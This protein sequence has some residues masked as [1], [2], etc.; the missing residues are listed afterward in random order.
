MSISQA[1]YNRAKQIMPGGVQLLSKRPEM[2][3]PE[4][5]PNYA[6][7]G[8][9]CQLWDLDGNCYYDMTTNGIGACLLGYADPDVSKAAIDRINNGCMTS[10]NAPEEV[11]LAE[12]LLGIHPWAE[13]VRFARTGGETCAIAVRIARATT[14]RDVIAICG[15]HGWADWYLACN[16]SEG[17]ALDGIHLAGL[18]PAGVPS[19][20]A[21]S[22]VTFHYNNV[23]EFDAIIA[24]YGDRL[25]GVIMEPLRSTMPNDGFLQHVCDEVHRVGGL[26]LFD[27][28][29]IGWRF[30][31]GGSHR[32]LGVQ[33]DI[34]VFAKA[35]GNGHPIGAIIGT[36]AA[37]DGAHNSFISSTYWTE[38]VGPTAA[39][40]TLEKMEK[41]RVWEHAAHIGSIIQKDWVEAAANGGVKVST[42]GVPCH[43]QFSWNEDCPKE[44]K[45]LFTKLMLAE[46]FM[47]TPLCYPTLAHNEEIL[48]KHRAALE[49]TFRTL[50][51]LLKNGGKEAVAEAIGGPVCHGDFQ[52]LLK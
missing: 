48:A 24:Q 50:G 6:A 11:E 32:V 22:A 16:L 41:T 46:G 28:I 19:G 49:K 37:M 7:R 43:A 5:W 4:Q 14:G 45:T 40:A 18:Q 13:S 2:F 39:L 30:T 29:S 12:R 44:L 15:Y 3:A 42:F 34:A 31:F 23:E 38:A 35:M 8:K 20:L 47:A 51:D 36:K 52:R 33:P 9:G 10:L 25:A 1:T 26:L 21:G 17:D 27:E